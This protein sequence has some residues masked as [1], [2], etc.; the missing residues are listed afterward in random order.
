MTPTSSAE[1]PVE[2]LDEPAPW[3]SPVPFL[4]LAVAMLV[5]AAVA[6]LLTGAADPPTDGE[7]RTRIVAAAGSATAGDFAFTMELSFDDVDESTLEGM[8][9]AME[10]R[11]D[12]DTK[13]LEGHA[14]G[15]PGFEMD[16]IV[17]D[18]VQY[19]RFPAASGFAEATG[20]KPWGRVERPERPEKADALPVTGNPLERLAE[21]GRLRSPIVRIGEERVRGVDTVRYRTTIETPETDEAQLDVWLDEDDGFRRL[22]QRSEINGTT[23]T[24]TFEVFDLGRPVDIQLPPEDQV[25]PFSPGNLFR[26][27]AS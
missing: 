14:T 25:G 17:A 5:T 12:A 24:T 23:L 4:W 20:G 2:E 3:R 16:L 7:A 15:S 10:G 8:T 18:R 1:V 11:Y 21:L 22:R 19:F 6:A 9:T 26:R 27:P 13:R